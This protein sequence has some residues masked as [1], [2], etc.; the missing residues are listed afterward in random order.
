MVDL[1]APD[2]NKFEEQMIHFI[3]A[4]YNIL[5]NENESDLK[6]IKYGTFNWYNKLI[7]LL[8]SFNEENDIKKGINLRK[9]EI[10]KYLKEI[11]RIKKKMEF[12]MVMNLAHF[13]YERYYHN[14][15]KK[16]NERNIYLEYNMTRCIYK[17]L[18]NLRNEL[19]HNQKGFP[20]LEY[21]LRI[22]E[23]FY[24][25][26]KFMK[27]DSHDIKVE[28][29]EQF[30]R[31]IKINIHIYLE[32]NLNYDKS[33]ELNSLIEEFK[34]FE[35]ENKIIDLKPY[36]K[37]KLD[38]KLLNDDTKNIIKSI[39]DFPEKLPKFDFNKEEN[40]N[41]NEIIN[42]LEKSN[43][44]DDK[45]EEEKIIDELSLDKSSHDSISDLGNFSSSSE[46]N[47]INENEGNIKKSDESNINNSDSKYDIQ[48]DI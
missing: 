7:E 3:E 5:K 17:E 13:L 22:Y 24:Y 29:D 20:P 42:N 25:L 1:I 34:K 37:I 8:N 14:I 4:Y 16:K 10:I 11:S 48:N 15:K 39:F 6:E 45:N 33:F 28:I 36:K 35:I 47:S 41:K 38:E 31:E 30:L 40:N 44:N 2:I 43:I 23:D 12:Y 18:I 9:E 26:I 27:P 21:I 32:K 19:S 46:R